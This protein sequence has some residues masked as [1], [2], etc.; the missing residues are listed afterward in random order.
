MSKI[1]KE[2]TRLYNRDGFLK[3]SIVVAEAKPVTSP[4][5]NVFEWNDKKAGAAYRL[6][7]A[8]RV[9]RSTPIEY[10]GEQA[11]MV[12]IQVTTPDQEG[13]YKP[14]PAVV[15]VQSDFDA[16]LGE[17]TQNVMGVQRTIDRLLSAGKNAKTP[18]VQQLARAIKRVSTLT[19][20]L[21]Q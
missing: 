16:A 3:P 1:S 13:V 5:H 6:D 9:I 21:V 4:L 7:Q 2:L 20:S 14:V 18:Q 8:R 17:L 11:E 19:S 12:H 10:A 15:N